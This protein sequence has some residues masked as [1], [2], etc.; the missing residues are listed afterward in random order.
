LHRKYVCRQ[1]SK[2]TI[3]AKMGILSGA[4][5]FP[6]F[7]VFLIPVYS[8]TSVIGAIHGMG[9]ESSLSNISQSNLLAGMKN[10]CL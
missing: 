9:G 8:R 2:K 3:Y 4:Y 6:I 10:G 1:R 5:D 7:T